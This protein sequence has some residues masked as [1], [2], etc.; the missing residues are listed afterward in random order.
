MKKIDD[1][2]SIISDIIKDLSIEEK[3]DSSKIFSKWPEI[4]GDEIGKKSKP[5]RLTGDTLY[6]SVVNS[7]WANELSLMSGQL[8][9]KINSFVGRE[10][11]KNLRFR[12]NI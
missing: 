10:A 8:I 2:G 4:V 9:E 11:V 3:L 7:I 1:I 6:I 12:Q 5:K